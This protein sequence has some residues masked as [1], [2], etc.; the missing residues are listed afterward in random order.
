MASTT[1][2]NVPQQS[3][4]T[5]QHD[6]SKIL[7]DYVQ[8][9]LT[10]EETFHFI[11]F[12]MLQRLNIAQLQLKLGEIK[13]KVK[14]ERRYELST[15]STKE[16]KK[17]CMIIVSKLSSFRSICHFLRFRDCSTGLRQGQLSDPHNTATAIQNYNILHAMEELPS[18][19][20]IERNLW[21]Q[22]HLKSTPLGNS[23][24][25][26]FDSH[27]FLL[28]HT[29]PDIDPVRNWLRINLPKTITYSEEEKIARKDEYE[30]S[31]PALQISPFVDTLARFLA[32]LVGGLFFIVPMLVMVLKPSKTT[33][34]VTT[35]VA[36]LL[37]SVSLAF[38]LKANNVDT[39]VSTAT[40]A[41]VL[42]VFVGSMFN[43]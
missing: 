34:L 12:E 18:E 28:T 15:A 10:W 25:R 39:L 30:S 8:D 35:T 5:T 21:L 17:P 40:H 16:L 42:V 4:K 14:E 43:H 3:E 26:P 1:P 33:N 27:Y 11:G 6:Y 24:R 31:R 36:V 19:D 32:A 7:Y 20:M 37:F 23:P 13:D 22:R 9:S 2:G 29:R 41:A 38:G